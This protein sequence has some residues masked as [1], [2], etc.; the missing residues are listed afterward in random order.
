MAISPHRSLIG[1]PSLD[2]IADDPSR[3]QELPGRTLATLAA[4]TAAIQ[5]AL[6]QQQIQLAAEPLRT[7]P[8][9]DRTLDADEIAVELG[10]DRRWVFRY[11]KRLPF[12]K[13]I[14]R[15]SLVASESAVKR[16]REA[17]KI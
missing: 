13:R 17:Q 2:E 6:A 5:A 15:K 7:A 16:W 8:A 14:S 3:L 11:A 12:I 1:V 4:R 9:S 10:V